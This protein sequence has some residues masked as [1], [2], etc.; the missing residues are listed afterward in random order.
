MSTNSSCHLLSHVLYLSGYSIIST[1]GLIMNIIAIYLFIHVNQLRSPTIVY[2]KN[3]AIADLLLICTVPLKIYSYTIEPS[4][5]NSNLQFWI[6][7]VF[8]SFL[9]L[10]MYSSIFLLTCISFDRYLAVCF[11]LRSRRLRQKAPWICV[12]VW[13]LNGISVIVNSIIFIE[14][15]NTNHSCLNG[16]PPFVTQKGPTIGAIGIGFLV[17]LVVMV[18]SS[19]AMLKSMNQSHVV[20]E[21]LVN[22]VKVIRMLATNT[23]IFLLCFLPY[24]LVLLFYQFMDNCFLEEAYQFTLLTACCNT[25]LDP[26]AYYFTTDTIRNVVREEIKAGKKFL[27]LSDHSSEKNRPIISS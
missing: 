8:G 19:V 1:L 17:P 20:Q 10:N 7:N 18:I 25:V 3:L 23:A 26:F 24:H 21:G 27:E 6:C 14:G 2:M 9:L 12:G 15:S 13:F 16:R 22:R 4:T 11:P 5:I